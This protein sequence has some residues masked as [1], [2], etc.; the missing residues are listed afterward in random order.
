M[1]VCKGGGGVR[2]KNTLSGDVDFVASR[3]KQCVFPKL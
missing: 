2:E 3:Y 1:C